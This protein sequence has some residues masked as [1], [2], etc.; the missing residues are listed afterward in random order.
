MS[1]L[2]LIRHSI[3]KQQPD[4]NASEWTLTQAGKILCEILAKQLFSFSIKHIYTSEEAKASLTGKIVAD[5]LNIPCEKVP[6]LQE[7]R[8]DSSVFFDSQDEFRAKVRDAMQN[9]DELRFG[10]ETF[11]DARKRFSAQVD[12]LIQDNL[13]ETLAIVT[14][15]RVMSIYLGHILKRDPVEIWDALAMPAYAVLSLPEKSLVTLVNSIQ[16]ET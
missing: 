3:S 9:P 16:G 14:H 13:N 1:K 8:R 6:N 2:I 7:T 12:A 10:D 11:A 5:A 15:G 4:V